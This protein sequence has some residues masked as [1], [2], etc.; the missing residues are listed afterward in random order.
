MSLV[1]VTL[2]PHVIMIDSANDHEGRE[3]FCIAGV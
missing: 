2:V 3:A 1:F